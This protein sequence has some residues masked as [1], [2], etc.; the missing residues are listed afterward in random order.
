MFVGRQNELETLARL[1]RKGSASLVVCSGRRRIGKSTLIEEFAAR[2]KCRFVEIVGLAPDAKMNNE[3]QLANF[4]GSLPSSGRRPPQTVTDWPAAFKALSKAIPRSGR[5]VVFLDEISWMGGYD[6]TFAAYL[7]NAWDVD[8]SRC[9]NLVFVI[10]GSVS[11]WIAT[12]ILNSRGFVGRISVNLKVDELPVGL[13]RSFWGRSADQVAT[14]EIV[15]LLSVTGGVPKYLQ[16]I[17]PALST[18]DNIRNLCFLPEGYLFEDFDRIFTDVF[19]RTPH[20]KRKI[21]ELLADGPRSAKEIATRLGYGRNGHLTAALSELKEAGFVTSDEGLNPATQKSVREVRYRIRD[22][23]VRF[24]LKC[25]APRAA[26][27]ARGLFRFRSL[28]QLPGWETLVGFQFESLVANNLQTLVPLIGL[29]DVLVTSAAPY[30]CLGRQ[31]GSGVQVD[32]LLQ[33][34]KS[35][36]VVEIKRRKRIDE[37]VETQVQEKIAR[38]ALPRE[39]SV[40]KALVYD[41]ELHPQIR[42][43]GYFDFLISADRLLGREL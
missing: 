13:C 37:N 4:M 43:N 22:N 12:N 14:G 16:E 35:V 1:W 19:S 8:F 23:Y 29:G 26:A 31:R 30:A 10:C 7:K 15:D 41:G 24:Y 2:S 40:R 27:I 17:D 28:E 36:C 32:L 25:I 18:A 11:A 33:T 5:T 34:R 42:E 21:V 3:K 38:L 6:E 39:I 9:D 20:D